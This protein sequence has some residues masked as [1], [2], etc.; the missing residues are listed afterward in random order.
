VNVT[1][2]NDPIVLITRHGLDLI[3]LV[4][5]LVCFGLATFLLYEPKSTRRKRI[6]WPFKT[7]QR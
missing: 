5:G 6:R 4:V 2:W 3:L 1:D 7:S